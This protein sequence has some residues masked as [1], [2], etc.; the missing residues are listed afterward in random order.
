MIGSS[1]LGE[2]DLSARKEKTRRHP[3]TQKILGKD[4]GE[5]I[6]NNSL[7]LGVNK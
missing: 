7:H 2:G 4:D 5:A 1:I 6:G 3:R